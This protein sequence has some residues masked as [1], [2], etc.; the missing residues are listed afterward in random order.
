MS[1]RVVKILFVVLCMFTLISMPKAKSLKQLREE[2]AKDEANKAALIAKQKNVQKK[3]NK[4]NSE[5]KDINAKIDSNEQKIEESKDKIEE[6]KVEIDEKQ[7]EI[8]NL[9]SFM[10]ETNKENV[11]LEY[12]FEA[13]TFTDF[14]YRSAVVEELTKYNDELIDDMYKMI[15]ENKKLQKELQRQIKASEDDIEEL[16]KL[17]KKYDLDMDD[18]A[19]EQVDIEADIKAR[20]V[21]LKE[22]E[23][24][25]KENNCKE[26]VDISKCVKVP[27]AGQFIRPLNKGYI[28]SL[29]GNRYHPTKKVWR[30]HNGVDIGGNAMGTKVYA[31]AAG[32]VCKIT[33]KSSCGGNMV[34][35]QHTVKGVNYRT[36]YMHLHS[37]K[38]KV[39]DYVTVNTVVGTVGGGER[40]DGCSTGP[41]LHLSVLKGWE[42]STYYNPM[43]YF[44]L[45]KKGKWFYSRF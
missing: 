33:V 12:V 1:K 36:I 15:E 23:K 37:I 17:L 27:P 19:D 31:A 44:D 18:L 38:V 35:V 8:D 7:K 42:G 22:Y 4:M 11:Y 39:G 45:P 34:Y 13:K 30:R 26:D 25:Y 2:L 16:Q 10:Q 40:Y 20:K 32:K 29:F 41:H 28:S 6:L 21:E 5:M 14:I 43:N 24:T 9:L 3:I